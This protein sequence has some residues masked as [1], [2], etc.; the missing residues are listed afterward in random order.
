MAQRFFHAT[1]GLRRG[2]PLCPFM[3]T[4]VANA[5]SQILREGEKHH[6]IKGFQVGKEGIPISHLQHAY[7]TLLFLDGDLHH[8]SNLNSIIR[9][10]EL[11]INWMK[12][13]FLGINTNNQ[14]YSDICHALDC[15]INNFPI[16]YLGAPLGGS[17]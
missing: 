15:K 13:Y 2:D 10:F 16:E 6:L 7:D 14:E 9:C 5:L 1:R 11:V 12:S 8:L 4:L 17:L 3:Y